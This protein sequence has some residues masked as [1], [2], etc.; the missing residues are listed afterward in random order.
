MKKIIYGII[1]IIIIIF[2]LL[3]ILLKINN[4]SSKSPD[5]YSIHEGKNEIVEKKENV[6]FSEYF[7]IKEC[8][9]KYV[10]YLNKNNSI[11]YEKQEDGTDH[12]NANIQREIV[13]S[14][15]DERFIKEN[16]LNKNNILEKI[17][18]FLNK[19]IF[20]PTNIKVL[21]NDSD[22][23]AYK[24]SGVIQDLDYTNRNEVYYIIF[25]DK[26]NETFSVM[27]INS[28]IYDSYK[29]NE[30]LGI[31]NKKEYNIYSLS[32]VEDQQ[33]ATEYFEAYKFLTLA[34]PKYT[35]EKMSEQ[36]RNRRFGSLQNYVE[37][38]KNNYDDF[39]NMIAQKYLT[40]YNGKYTQYVIQ[41]QNQNYY[42]FDILDALEY[43]VSLDNYT[44]DTEKFKATYANVDSK[45]RVQMN[46]DKFFQMINRQDYRTS[47]NVL[48]DEFKANKLKTQ[49]QFEN[50]IKNNLFK[51]NKISFLEYK[52]LGSNTYSFNIKLTDLIE[53][54]GGEVKMTIIM[55]LKENTDFV[56]SFSFNK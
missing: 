36:Y 17:Q 4:N 11:Y 20:Y 13:C 28:R 43:N 29:L 44:I 2:I 19:E 18:L 54:K 48:S 25:I 8:I 53:K 40:N 15:L 42:I 47:Y 51:Y 30:K 31:I 27:P 24:I 22:S 45:K 49:L 14:L 39:K 41:D 10:D 9:Q 23:T 37:Y 32:N 56:M 34:N 50:V 1:S 7:I 16:N 46:I 35:Y 3:L 5:N 52:D 38:V 33:I 21:N 55:Q 6:Q 26:N 12:Y